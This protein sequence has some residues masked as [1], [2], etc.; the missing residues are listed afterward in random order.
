MFARMATAICMLI[1][2]SV[3]SAQRQLTPVPVEHDDTPQLNELLDT[4]DD[5][6]RV[7]AVETRVVE[8]GWWNQMVQSS[9]RR[10][11]TT[12]PLTLEGAIIRALAHSKQIKVFS[13]TPLVRQTSIVEADAAFDWSAFLDSRWDD[14][15]DPVGNS[16]TAGP[17]I[18]RFRDHNLS[19][20]AGARKKNFLWRQPGGRSAIRH[21]KQQ[22]AI[23][24]ATGSRNVANCS[25]LHATVDAWPRQ[26]LQS[27]PCVPGID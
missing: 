9:L 18:T 3:A 24:Y 22:L 27:Q 11:A 1:L 12:I 10:E 4:A 17:G 5:F 7:D 2:T 8:R 19:L 23:L 14:T 21:A 20:S 6:D 15:S 26:G 13:E 25:Q 16:L